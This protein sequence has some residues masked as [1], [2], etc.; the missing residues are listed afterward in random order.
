MSKNL[1]KSNLEWLDLSKNSYLQLNTNIYDDLSGIERASHLLKEWTGIN[2]PPN[3][4]NRSLITGRLGPVLRTLNI[5]TLTEYIDHLEK[6][7]SRELIPQFIH[8]MT[9]NTTE[10]F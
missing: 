6:L 7:S 8:A 4:K 3:E 1:K 10:F 5:K 2:L 9:T